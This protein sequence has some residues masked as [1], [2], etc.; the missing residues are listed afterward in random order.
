MFKIRYYLILLVY[1]CIPT[2]SFA[3]INVLASIQPIHSLVAMVMNGIAEPKL[4]LDR[5]GSPHTY[6][7]TPLNAREIQEADIIFWIGPQIETFLIKPLNTI[8]RKKKI[9]KLNER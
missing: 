1:I 9:V 3:E 2:K 8:N 7:L 6:S 5:S 4:I